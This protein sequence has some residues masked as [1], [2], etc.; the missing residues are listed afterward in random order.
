MYS[1]VWRT[2]VFWVDLAKWLAILLG[3]SGSSPLYYGLSGSV[4]QCWMCGEAAPLSQQ[5]LAFL[6]QV[7]LPVHL[8]I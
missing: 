8:P 6:Q 5:L 4:W 7:F 1:K 3:D 2:K